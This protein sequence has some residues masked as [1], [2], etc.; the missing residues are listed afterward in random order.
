[1]LLYAIWGVQCVRMFIFSCEEKAVLNCMI[2][3]VEVHGSESC[4]DRSF[5]YNYKQCLSTPHFMRATRKWRRE[6]GPGKIEG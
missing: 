3:N 5:S 4:L 2:I 1:M 6:R